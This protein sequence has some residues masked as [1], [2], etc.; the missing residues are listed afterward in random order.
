MDQTRYITKTQDHGFV[1]SKVVSLLLG[2]CAFYEKERHAITDYPFV[3][4]QIRAC[5]AKHVELQNVVGALMDQ[6]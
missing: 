4:F 5:I 3:P 1:D 6:S 2:I